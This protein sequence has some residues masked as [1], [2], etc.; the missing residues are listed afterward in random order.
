MII[1]ELLVKLGVV[2][3][4]TKVKNFDAAVEGVKT[5]LQGLADFGRKAAFAISAVAT[6]AGLQALA[7][8]NAAQEIER[9]A[10][11]LGMSTDAYQE[12]KA[13]VGEFGVDSKGLSDGFGHVAEVIGQAE[14]GSAGAIAMFRSLGISM[15]DL[16]G[17]SVD[18]AMGL[19]ADG[20][21][22]TTD[23]GDRLRA[24]NMLLGGD[25]AT[26]LG[27]LLQQG[28]EGLARYRREAH[29]LGVVLDR[30][31]IEKGKAAAQQFQHFGLILQGVRNEIG[32]AVLPTVLR[33][34]ASLG[35]F[36]GHNRE[37]IGQ[38]LENVVAKIGDG[39]DR[40]AGAVKR[41]DAEVKERVGGWDNV[42]RRAQ[43]AL[44]LLA[45]GKA[46]GMLSSALMV[47]T[48]GFKA[49]TAS[50]GLLAGASL[51]TVLGWA[52]ALAAALVGL[53]LVVDD[54]IAYFSGGESVIGDF[55]DSSEMARDIVAALA[56]A[57]AAFG[58]VLP[59]L[60]EGIREVA[61][62]LAPLVSF[63][64]P[65]IEQIASFL[66]TVAGNTLLAGLKAMAAGFRVL[67]ADIELVVGTLRDLYGLI[68][69]DTSMGDAL[70]RFGDRVGK[71]V[72]AGGAS[73]A[74]T[75]LAI[76]VLA[77]ITGGGLPGGGAS[78]RAP[79]PSTVPVQGPMVSTS[80]GTTNTIGGDTIN[81]YGMTAAQ[82][83]ELQVRQGQIKGR[84]LTALAGAAL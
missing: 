45:G 73:I 79:A 77:Q 38:R 41:V 2:A 56:D 55:L 76:P 12:W 24:S 25:L 36:L 68:T 3:D 67:A 63:M 57:M 75:T 5:N 4:T 60:W 31:S 19:I 27:P 61:S 50:T 28:S 47:A 20:F 53:Y 54:L 17:A 6:A 26:R 59:P 35:D 32:L 16:K 48:E 37:I 30:A 39:Y 80:G 10:G 84:S 70:G 7:T 64:E 74:Q 81:V 52:A 66:A 21:Q 43:A 58:E 29:A 69:G 78:L 51:G 83:E 11:A 40:L 8:A 18:K 14:E 34:V 82:L 1:R 46:W 13:T 49:L 23:A 62:A 72:K 9:Q 33:L 44:L 15:A 22:R 71:L 42:L 65:A